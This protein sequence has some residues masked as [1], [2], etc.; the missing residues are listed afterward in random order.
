MSEKI[1]LTMDLVALRDVLSKL[2][3]AKTL[4]AR[5]NSIEDLE[6]RISVIEAKIENIKVVGDNFCTVNLI[7]G[8][9]RLSGSCENCRF[10]KK[11]PDFD[12][13]EFYGDFENCLSDEAN[14]SA[15]KLQLESLEQSS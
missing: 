7:C 15:L 2:K 11:D 9:T 14:I 4:Q 5:Y 10:Y 6:S 13:C 1:N 8:G 12:E 3:I